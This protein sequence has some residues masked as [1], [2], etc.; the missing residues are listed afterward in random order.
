MVISV[1]IL[2]QINNPDT[3][4]G[5]VAGLTVGFRP[6]EKKN[7]NHT[8]LFLS[9]PATGMQRQSASHFTA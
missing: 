2:C 7:M 6:K 4:S 1:L 8:D 3:L 5:Y 9:N